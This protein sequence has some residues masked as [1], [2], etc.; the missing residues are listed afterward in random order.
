[1]QGRGGGSRTWRRGRRTIAGALCLGTAFALGLA[2]TPAGAAHHWAVAA[3]P[4]TPV[5]IATTADAESV[6]AAEPPGTTFEI[7]AGLHA[8]NFSVEPRAG[9]VFEADPGAVLDGGYGCAACTQVRDAFHAGQH[10]RTADGVVI[11][12]SGPAALLVIQNYD[13]GAGSSPEQH[14]AIDPQ[15]NCNGGAWAAGWTVDDTQVTGSYSRGISVAPGMT[16]ESST[17]DHN[18]RLGIGGGDGN[19]GTVTIVDDTVVDNNTRGVCTAPSECGGIKLTATGGAQITKNVINDNT[20]PGVWFDGGSGT[21]TDPDLVANNVIDGNT[22]AAVRD[23]ISA[24]I[25]VSQNEM[26]GDGS[27]PTHAVVL[28]VSCNSLTVSNNTIA[29]IGARS[30]ILIYQDAR[31]AQFPVDNVDVVGNSI[32]APRGSSVRDGVD[33]CTDTAVCNGAVYHANVVFSHNAYS[34]AGFEWGSSSATFAAGSPGSVSW[35]QWKSHGLDTTGT[36]SC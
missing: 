13:Q 9:D 32:G 8:Q 24:N 28:C 5:L 27:D 2:A 30:G 19:T 20:G 11:R 3:P 10:W 31:A 34:C 12:G 14:G 25:V 18:G 36:Y 22:G 35:T 15:C 7:Q 17:V 23:E 33:Q 26:V 16:I 21:P 4:G 6:V 1:M 29:D